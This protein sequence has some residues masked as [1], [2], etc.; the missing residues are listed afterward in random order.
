MPAAEIPRIIIRDA[1]AEDAVCIGVL[2]MQERAALIG[3]HLEIRSAP[4]QGSTLRLHCPLR[5][6]GESS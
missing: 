1:I 2:G 3:G 5:R 6:I 4:G